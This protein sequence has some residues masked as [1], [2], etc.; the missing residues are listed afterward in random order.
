VAG[1]RRAGERGDERG[2]GCGAGEQGSLADAGPPLVEPVQQPGDRLGVAVVAERGIDVMEEAG[3]E[4]RCTGGLPGDQ[5]GSYAGVPVPR[6]GGQ[7]RGDL[8]G[9]RGCRRRPAAGLGQG[10]GDQGAGQPRQQ[11]RGADV[12]ADV[13]D[14]DLDGGVARG[15]P[16]Q[17]VGAQLVTDDAMLAVAL[18]HRDQGLSLRDIAA[19]LV[20]TIGKKKGQHP[21]PSCACCASTTVRR[22]RKLLS[23][24]PADHN[25]EH[26]RATFPLAVAIGVLERSQPGQHT[27]QLPRL[28]VQAS[29]LVTFAALALIALIAVPAIS[30]AVIHGGRGWAASP[31]A[32]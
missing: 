29:R 31:P 2:R 19:R 11:H 12:E 1:Q 23:R 10:G 4:R 27:R 15:Q 20:I 22:H 18:H 30:L 25:P 8:P 3:A 5:V 21:P 14:P 24:W 28:T 13:G 6:R 32:A 9:R 26:P 7:G 17:E 16:G